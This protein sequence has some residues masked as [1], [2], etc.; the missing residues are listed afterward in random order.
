MVE[1]DIM[2]I[3]RQAG[4]FRITLA[5][6]LTWLIL[7]LLVLNF[8][9]YD[10][11]PPNERITQLVEKLKMLQKKD[12]ELTNLVI[13]FS[14][15]LK[16]GD[17]QKLLNKLKQV[18]GYHDVQLE[19]SVDYEETRR[20]IET[21]IH[22]LWFYVR[23]QIINLQQKENSQLLKNQ[24]NAMADMISQYK[25]LLLKD[26][27]SLNEKDGYTK[28]RENEHKSLHS[29][30]QRRLSHLQNPDNCETAKKLVCDLNKGCGFGC[31]LHHVVYC[32]IV[33]YAT[34]RTMILNSHG[35]RYN[36]LGWEKVFL[37]VSN[38]CLSETGETRRKWPGTRST[39]VIVLPIIDSIS[40]RPNYLPLAIPEDL[41][42]RLTRIH[43]DPIVW[44]IGQFLHFILRPQPSVKQMLDKYAEEMHFDK[45]IV[46]IHVRRTDKVGTEAA[47]HGLEEYMVYVEEYYKSL[48]LS[49]D[50]KKKR[51]YIA[52]DE[53]TVFNEAKL[54]FP[55]YEIIGNYSIS[56]TASI[57]NR[58]T[59]TSL[60]GIIIDIY[61]LSLCDYLV[62]T[63][64][65]QVCRV[66]YELMNS[67]YPDASKR[68]HS[69]DDIYYYGGQKARYQR[70]ILPHVASN[71]QEIDLQ[72]DDVISVAGN[73][74]NGYS[75]G[76]NLRTYKH[77]LYPSF[78]VVPKVETALFPTYPNVPQEVASSS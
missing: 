10:S 69:L 31:Q 48:A 11:V 76:T 23:S 15:R 7:M 77:G 25:R 19:P 5:V 64:S 34:E 32:F 54:K 14:S 57:G 30:V 46:G 63:F 35:W 20:R 4:C 51:V 26:V 42:T 6:S 17:Q 59:E 60:Y 39:Q 18:T 75:K 12:L 28:W 43:G 33:A 3:L 21:N 62:C 67:V 49:Q 58:Y 53:P 74:W 65:S 44:W 29:L 41:E 40:P 16:D 56:Q 68:F 1:S 55:D 38:T 45:P 72:I 36:R 9:Q 8:L 2:K 50:I 22:E 27:L 47:F 73:H 70:A 61:F 52:S 13:N 37:P 24:F 66:A 78:K 71:S